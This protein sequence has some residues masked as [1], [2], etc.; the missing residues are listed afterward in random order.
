MGD[1]GDPNE[2]G[3]SDVRWGD[4]IGP[5]ERGDSDVGGGTLGTLI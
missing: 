5:N 3:D 2:R 4:F 1:F